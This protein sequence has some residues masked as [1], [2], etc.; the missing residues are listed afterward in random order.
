[1]KQILSELKKGKLSFGLIM[2]YYVIIT[3]TQIRSLW[4][5]AIIVM[6]IKSPVLKDCNLYRSTSENCSAIPTV[7]IEGYCCISQFV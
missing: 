1:M 5:N 6:Y 7:L 2:M 4:N 3:S